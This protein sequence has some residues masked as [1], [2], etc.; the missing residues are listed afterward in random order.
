MLKKRPMEAGFFVFE[1]EVEEEKDDL[2]E[3]SLADIL[4]GKKEDGVTGLV[5]LIEQFME[6][7]KWSQED[8][9]YIRQF[10]DF[11]VRRAK[12]ELMTGAA[13]I[14]EIVLNHPTYKKDSVVND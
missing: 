11:L 4:A 5:P 3:L 1:Q 8:R 7:A 9:S 10:T 6:D 14:R 13:F 12:G 2:V